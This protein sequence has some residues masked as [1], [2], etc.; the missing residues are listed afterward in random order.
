MSTNNA[1]NLPTV[2]PVT[3]GGTGR[4]SMPAS[5]V[6]CGGVDP[7]DA[8][9]TVSG[10]GS[11]YESLTSNGAASLPSWMAAAGSVT[12][13]TTQ[14]ASMS[15]HLT[16]TSTAITPTYTYY[17]FWLSN[18]VNDDA[19]ATL[20]MMFS[21]DN[22][23]TYLASDYLS[24]TNTNLFNTT[25]FSNTNSTTTQ[26]LTRSLT[27]SGTTLCGYL[28]TTIPQNSMTSYNGQV[29]VKDTASILG[30]CFGRNTTTTT[31]NNV[32]FQFSGGVLIRSG[33]ISLYGL[34]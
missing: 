15:P 34:L 10:V 27:N 18:I 17:L 29:F 32:R 9:Q 19:P 33:T 20:E 4:A 6:I 14:T 25:T 22:G 21:T 26:P 23:A 30:F 28:N 8:L 5:S 1:A 31:V 3:R 16:F 24:G 2:A 7:T 12:L 11:I 13:L